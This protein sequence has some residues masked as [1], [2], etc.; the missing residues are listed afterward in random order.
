MG[1]TGR[2]EFIV[3]RGEDVWI[4]DQQGRRYL[5]ASASLWY[6]NVGH[7]RRELAEAAARQM[8]ELAAFQ[9][10]LH[11]MTGQVDIV[12]GSPIAGRTQLEAEKLLGPDSRFD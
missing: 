9:T 1:S 12:L 3:D 11:R 4:Y 6:A 7:G 8:G 2:G 10:L 5:D